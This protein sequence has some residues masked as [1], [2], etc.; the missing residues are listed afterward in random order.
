MKHSYLLIITMLSLA[1]ALSAQSPW[2]SVTAANVTLEYRILAGGET[3]ECKLMG[4]TTGWVAV[5]FNPTSVMRNANIIIGFVSGGTAS[6]RDDWGTSNT[7]HSADTS[8]GGTSDVALIEGMETAGITTLHFT[9]PLSTA[10]QYDRPMM[11]GQTYPIIL[12]R[13]SNNADNYTG[14]HAG[15]DFAQISLV[16]PVSNEDSHNGTLS[17]VRILGNYPNPFNPNTSIR[18]SVDKAGLTSLQIYNSRGQLVLNK[19][20]EA[21]KAGEGVFAWNGLDNRGKTCP[22]GIYTVRLQSGESWS[23]HRI[24][25]MK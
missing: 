21:S 19:S 25:L 18:Y 12:A 16:A 2:Q 5:G 15:A 13:G 8:L 22:S 14:M 6:I 4:E 11:V 9:I 20:L 24:T 23:K 7:S 3:L 10:D 1:F 17:P